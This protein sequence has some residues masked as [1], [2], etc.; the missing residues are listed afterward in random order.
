[1]ENDCIN[2]Y[3]CRLCYLTAH[4]SQYPLR[5]QLIMYACAYPDN[6]EMCKDYKQDPVK[7]KT[8]RITEIKPEYVD[9]VPALSG[10][11]EGVLYINKNDKWT[12]HLCPCG[13]GK[14]VM[15]PIGDYAW[16]LTERDKGVTMRPSVGNFDFPCKSHYYITVNKIEWL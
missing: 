11:K 9:N 15:L 1:M 7:R 6:C 13:C 12:L 16:T 3:K 4:E 10:M 8:M 5:G 2:L 14:P